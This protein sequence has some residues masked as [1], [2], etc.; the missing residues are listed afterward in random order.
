M[1]LVRLVTKMSNY[2]AKKTNKKFSQKLQLQD[3][4]SADDEDDNN[5]EE[6]VVKK[7]K[8]RK[9]KPL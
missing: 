4:V 7:K 2:P 6:V 8:R 3:I 1:I 9:A 5:E